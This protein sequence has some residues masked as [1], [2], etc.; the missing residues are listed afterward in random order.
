MPSKHGVIIKIILI[1]K[2]QKNTYLQVYIFVDAQDKDNGDIYYYPGSN[3]EEFMP[4]IYAVSY[5]E[6]FEEKGVSHP[7][8]KIEVPEKYE[9]V[10]FSIFSCFFFSSL[11][12]NS[13]PTGLG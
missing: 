4:Y 8:R 6:A 7:G 13:L 11:I 3:H 9:K 5:K 2:R 1:H 10:E 12:L